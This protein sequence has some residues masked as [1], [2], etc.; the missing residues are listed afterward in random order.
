MRLTPFLLVASLA[1]GAGAIT[2]AATAG[3]QTAPVVAQPNAPTMLTAQT[4]GSIVRYIVGPMGHV[5][6]LALDN[7]AIVWVHGRGGDALAQS[8][9]V[10]TSVRV[11]GMAPAATPHVIHR[12]TVFAANGTVLA[13]PPANVPAG[14]M[15][16]MPGRMHDPAMRAAAMARLAQLP[17]H[18]ASGV[19]QMVVPGPRGHVHILLLSDGSTV[20]LRG[21]IAREVNRHGVRIGETVQITGRGNSYPQGAAL[22][23]QSVTFSDGA[24]VS[25]PAMA[26][27]EARP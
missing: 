1:A 16:M 8:T 12:A 18:T 15:G 10:G 14:G 6:G 22:F 21:P 5:R 17:S 26:A 13:A 11:E 3:A 19:V 27:P 24:S 7:G 2:A 9:P 23:A 4:S 20:Y 25:A